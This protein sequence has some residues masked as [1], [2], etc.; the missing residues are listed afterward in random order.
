MLYFPHGV[1]SY[2]DAVRELDSGVGQILSKLKSLGVDKD[3]LVI[4]SSDNGGATY[5]KEMGKMEA[6]EGWV[7]RSLKSSLLR[8]S[9]DCS[10]QVVVYQLPNTFL[11]LLATRTHTHTHTHTQTRW[12]Q[13]T[14]AV[15]QRNNI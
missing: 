10:N 13:R 2:G 12:F 5:A 11:S 8:M 7:E 6:V 14:T 15:W 3:T 4:F 1:G 9:V